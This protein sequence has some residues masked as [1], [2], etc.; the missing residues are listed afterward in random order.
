M[1]KIKRNKTEQ[2]KRKCNKFNENGIKWNF[3]KYNYETGQSIDSSVVTYGKLGV[4]IF[5]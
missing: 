5:Y 1:N 3:F 2:N 4:I